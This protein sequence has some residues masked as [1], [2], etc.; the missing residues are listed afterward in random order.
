MAGGDTKANS[1]ADLRH[2]VNQKLDHVA[3][4][5][6]GAVA[7]VSAALA[8]FGVGSDRAWTLMDND[9]VAPD[10]R[11][12]GLLAVAAVALA[13]VSYLQPHTRNVLEAILLTLGIAAYVS[14]LLLAMTGAASAANT[15]GRPS[16]TAVSVTDVGGER[17]LGF[18]ARA[19]SVDPDQRLGIRVTA[20]GSTVLFE[21][22][23]RPTQG[24]TAALVVTLPV[25]DPSAALEIAAWRL[26]DPD[27][28]DCGR[29]SMNQL[30]GCVSINP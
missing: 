16:I 19:D 2:E 3:T 9:S 24:G 27:G 13:L 25:D 18:T 26:D 12:A 7:A 21:S 14:S 6:I 17:L 22:D 8:L 5:L 10:I 30:S 28:P 4:V 1:T 15:P 29:P 20:D 11:K 23:V